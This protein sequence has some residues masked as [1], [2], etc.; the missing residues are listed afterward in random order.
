MKHI[1]GIKDAL[2]CATIAIAFIWAIYPYT[3]VV[4]FYF[5]KNGN[6]TWTWDFW[7]FISLGET[8]AII[9][10]LLVYIILKLSRRNFEIT[11][12]EMKKVTY[13][14]LLK[15]YIEKKNRC[16]LELEDYVIELIAKGEMYLYRVFKEN[17]LLKEECFSSSEEILS[18]KILFS[19][20]LEE[21]LKKSYF[22][23]TSGIVYE[24]AADE[25][26]AYSGE[27]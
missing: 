1:R 17:K 2:I 20:N 27:G 6:H 9:I 25:D 26:N 4:I 18:K 14:E 8:I 11:L 19:Q 21:L 3:V 5:P 12:V 15:E 10:A 16:E 13:E 24:E 7:A 22:R 23:L